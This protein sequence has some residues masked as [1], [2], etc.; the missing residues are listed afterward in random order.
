MGALSKKLRN[1][2]TADGTK[3]GIGHWC[4]GCE[5]A[6]VIYT[7]N[8]G[9]PTWTWDGNVD[10]PTCTPSVRC[11]TRFDEDG[12]PLPD[13]GERTLC[14]YVLTAGVI[15]YCGDCGYH[16]LSNQQVPLPDFSDDYGGF[17]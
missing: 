1:F 2:G 11:F 16:G 10:A 17:D 3:A 8:P 13:N 4:P 9:G 5:S 12:K 15:N 7:K 14:H 6:H